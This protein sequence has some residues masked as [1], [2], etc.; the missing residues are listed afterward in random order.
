MS[1]GSDEISGRL[2][3]T[4]AQLSEAEARRLLIEA[5]RRTSRR[6]SG[7]RIVLTLDGLLSCAADG[8]DFSS[9]AGYER[10]RQQQAHPEERPSAE[11]IAAAFENRWS[12]A[13]LAAGLPITP[14]RRAQQRNIQTGGY[15]S[16]EMATAL[17]TWLAETT[18]V[19]FTFRAYEAWARARLEPHPEDRLPLSAPTFRAAFGSWQRAIDL[20]IGGSTHSRRGRGV[21][22]NYDEQ[23]MVVHLTAAATDTGLGAA[24]T[25]PAYD[26]WSRTRPVET[27]DRPPHSETFR[28][29][30]GSWPAALV[31]AGLRP[32]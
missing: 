28:R 13:L 10:W 26:A 17:N 24:L 1:D 16:Q 5:A 2:T 7:V 20:A 6:A 12:A 14:G 22:N 8:G 3:A 18:G 30:F 29:R 23:R 19:D 15:S 4:I 32:I 9:A 11:F 21:R 31:A 27:S 25:R